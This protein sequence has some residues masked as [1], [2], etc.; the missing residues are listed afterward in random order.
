M[1]KWLIV[2]A[3]ILALGW[4]TWRRPRLTSSVLWS[5]TATLGLVAGLILLLPTAIKPTLLWM[6]I[7]TPLVWVACIFWCHWDLSPRRP[8][9]GLIALTLAGGAVVFLAPS[10]MAG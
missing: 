2:A 6:S 7:V 8:A 3:S 10:P 5:L 4:A 1:V 9:A